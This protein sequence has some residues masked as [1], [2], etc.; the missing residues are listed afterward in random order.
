MTI[1]TFTEIHR[2]GNG[3]SAAFLW[4]FRWICREGLEMD[5]AFWIWR[6]ISSSLYTPQKLTRD[7]PEYLCIYPMCTFILAFTNPPSDITATHGIDPSRQL[8]TLCAIVLWMKLI[9][10]G[11][12][13]RASRTRWSPTLDLSTIQP[14]PERVRLG[15]DFC[16]P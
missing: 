3:T 13:G 10:Q 11:C 5:H 2:L 16:G 4:K 7:E 9:L 14:M 15:C 8:P 1:C 12:H 6:S